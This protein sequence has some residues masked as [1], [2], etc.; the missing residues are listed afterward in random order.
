M[1]TA[2]PKSESLFSAGHTACAGCPMPTII[3][4]VLAATGPD[5][6]VV[7][8]TSC[9]EIISSAY[10]RSAWG[11]P[12]IHSVFENAPAVA[13][14]VVHA[15]RAQG[16]AHTKVAIIAGDGSTYDIGFGAL[17]GMLERN[18]DVLYVCYDN[19]AYMNTG[20]Q[21]SGATPF[22]ARTTTSPVGTAHR[23]KELGK[24]PIVA[25]VA[26]HGV[27]YAAS[28]SIGYPADLSAK[29]AKAVSLTGSRFLSV[30]SPCIP[31]WGIPSNSAIN[32]AKLAVDSGI[33]KLFEYDAG[34]YRVTCSPPRRAPVKDYFS[35]QARFKH[36][37][38]ADVAEIQ[39]AVDASWQAP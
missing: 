33:W 34:A 3:R 13:T 11:V 17:S 29:L 32:Y 26:A 37:T 15:L 31:G 10:P 14:G 4:A 6:V 18:E 8:A 9:S 12:Y 35:G 38:D 1:A 22:R 5:V 28:A 23:G 27:P 24:K 2:E 39:K 25:I 20:V 30:L 19:E 7:N 36:L 16:N 21:R